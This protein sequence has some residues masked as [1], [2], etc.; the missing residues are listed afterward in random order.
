MLYYSC[1]EFD[2]R[3]WLTLGP[4]P[5]EEDCVQVNSNE[6]Y[7]PAMNKE[8]RKF[9]EFL[10]NRFLNIPENA[11]FGVK[12]ENHDFGTYKEAAIFW[13]TEDEESE[14]F[15]FFVES[16]IPARWDDTEQIDW[17]KTPVPA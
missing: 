13:D 9:V 2:M 10:Q 4:V 16:N 5:Y 3:E 11:Y 8:V 17:K 14:Q 7:L 12:S 1:K 15:A 6:D